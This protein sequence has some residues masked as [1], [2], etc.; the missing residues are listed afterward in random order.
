MEYFYTSKDNVEEHNSSLIITGTEH[1]HLTKVLKKRINDK[2]TVTDG[3]LN[4]YFCEIINIGKHEIRCNILSRKN[5]IFEP[6]LK[7]TLCLCLLKNLDRYEFAIEKA[8][9]LGITEIIPVISE[10]TINKSGLSDLKIQRL[11]SIVLSA[12]KQ[13]QRCY[14]PAVQKCIDFQKLLLISKDYET[15]ILMYE[16]AD[17]TCKIENRNFKKNCLLLIGPEGGFSKEEV[18]SLELGGWLIYS[19]GDRKLRTE[20]AAIISVYKILNNLIY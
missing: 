10:Y 8:V 12:M 2:I 17:S 11:N 14:L 20:T 4:V 3:K 5:N 16:F 18:K 7:L 19:L 9:E 1:K 15:K 13:S 6:E